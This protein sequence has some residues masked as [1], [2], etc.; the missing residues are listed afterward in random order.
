MGS[1]VDT[2]VSFVVASELT[3][4]DVGTR[5]MPQSDA[6]TVTRKGT[7]PAFHFGMAKLLAKVTVEVGL[8][9]H[10]Y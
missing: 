6:R 5:T 8:A 9:V 2:G 7:K 3:A 1:W 10:G 4:F